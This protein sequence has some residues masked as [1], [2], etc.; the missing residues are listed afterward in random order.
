VAN[1]GSNT[2]VRHFQRLEICQ[3]AITPLDFFV[4]VA[5]A[6]ISTC[7]G[8][9]RLTHETPFVILYIISTPLSA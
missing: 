9:K 5:D 3:W 6:M 1:S 2:K 8:T 7:M 4:C